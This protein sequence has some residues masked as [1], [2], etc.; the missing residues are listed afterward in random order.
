MDNYYRVGLRKGLYYFEV[1][2]YDA[3]GN[4]EHIIHQSEPDYNSATEATDAA[5][6]WLE[7]NNM[8]AELE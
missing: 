8:E 6:E 2:T 3:S 7:D 4:N 1:Y 5:A